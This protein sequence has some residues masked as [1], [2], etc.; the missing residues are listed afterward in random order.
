MEAVEVGESI[1]SAARFF[2]IPPTSL[3]D[4]LY[5]RSVGRKRD[6][7]GVLSACEE[8]ELVEYVLKM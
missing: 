1:R 5:G 7:Q 4:H 6:K 3:R 2:G 8:A